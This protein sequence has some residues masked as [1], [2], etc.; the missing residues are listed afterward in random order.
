LISADEFF[1]IS[2]DWGINWFQPKLLTKEGKIPTIY[3]L[4]IANDDIYILT[5][6]GIFFSKDKGINW[7][8][9]S[10][11]NFDF[12]DC[13]S[14]T[15]IDNKYF[16]QIRNNLYM[17]ADSCKSWRLITEN[18]PKYYIPNNYLVWIYS[19]SKII[20]TSG[21]KLYSSED[22]GDSWELIY[23]FP[24]NMRINTLNKCDNI[25]YAT[26]N[27]SGVIL[28]ST[29]G[30]NWINTMGGIQ[31]NFTAIMAFNKDF[32]FCSVGELGYYSDGI[33]KMKIENCLPVIE[34]PVEEE[35]IAETVKPYP[36]PA[37]D[38]ITV[39]LPE[40][41]LQAVNYEV[42]NA[43]GEKVILNKY[44]EINGNKIEID[45]SPL[46][47]GVYYFSYLSGGKRLRAQFIKR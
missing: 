14:L 30:K 11:D 36:N 34:T 44:P 12:F 38:M 18:L 1:Y 19:D 24:E 22:F 23:E 10:N 45:V 33:Y 5:D 43:L 2:N 35:P 28:S 42:Y 25:L 4:E 9:F 29:N 47:P 8:K 21:V 37:S 27:N 7:F 20:A 17:S 41:A 15:I 40:G 46:S 16:I 26:T 32:A 39:E 6:Q 3:D 31:E 13:Y